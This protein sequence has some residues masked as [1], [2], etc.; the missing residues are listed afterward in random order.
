MRIPVIVISGFLGSGKTTYLLHLLKEIRSR[1]LQPGILMNELG[2]SDVDGIILDE[3]SGETMEKLLDGCVCCS[4]KSELISSLTT[5]LKSKPDVILIELTG[6]ANPEEIADAITE[7]G[8]IQHM[9]LKQIV[10]V[11]DAENVLDYNSVFSSDKQLVQTLRRQIEV[12]DQIIVNKTDLVKESHLR[13]VKNM[14]MKHNENALITF[15]TH[16]R[17]DH[18]SILS[19][20]VKST[21]EQKVNIQRFRMI[22]PASLSQA[23]STVSRVN[24]SHAEEYRSFARVQSLT[25]PIESRTAVTQENIERFLQRWKDKLLRA[26]GYMYLSNQNKT[27]LMQHAGK[28][29]YWEETSYL[30]DAYI[31]IIGIELDIDRILSDWKSI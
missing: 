5:L 15:A 26:K 30:G 29:T 4:K 24:D 25:L 22:N 28:R 18:T 21:G 19:G 13:K 10:T 12:A 7:P 17:V 2:K 16:S 9:S 11:L 23:K 27:L 8:L 31:V 20:I 14:I 1:Y 3:H 6:V